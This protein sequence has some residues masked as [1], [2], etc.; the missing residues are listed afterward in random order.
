M[1][2]RF[3]DQFQDGFRQEKRNLYQN[4]Y[5]IRNQHEKLSRLKYVSI[6]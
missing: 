6:I 1:F 4:E 5:Q 3:F 2:L